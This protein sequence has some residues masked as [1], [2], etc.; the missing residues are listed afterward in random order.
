MKKEKV[1]H[2]NGVDTTSKLI[3]FTI[4]DAIVNPEYNLQSILGKIV[5]N[6]KYTPAKGDKIWIFPHSNIPRFKLKE[7]CK[8]YGTSIVK[9]ESKATAKFVGTDYLFKI[10]DV[11]SNFYKF[12]MTQVLEWLQRS[13]DKSKVYFEY[14]QKEDRLTIKEFINLL[15]E[16]GINE[17]Y[18][19]K[20]DTLQFTGSEHEKDHLFKSNILLSEEEEE[21]LDEEGNLYSIVTPIIG[22]EAEF[23]QILTDPLIYHQDELLAKISGAVMTE[24]MYNRV[25]E[26][27]ESEDVENKKLAIEAMGSCD[28]QKSAVYLLLLLYTNSDEIQYVSSKNHV[29]FKSLLRFFNLRNEKNVRS[30]DDII[31]CLKYQKLFNLTNLNILMP[32]AMEHIRENGEMQNIKIKDVE[33]SPEAESALAENILDSRVEIV[34]DP[35]ESVLGDL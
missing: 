30:I 24:D 10:M 8:N 26:M 1:I 33:L 6:R 20:H 16:S 29:N 21:K 34:E 13:E 27:L 17:V 31:E 5:E 9:E 3:H 19:D 35:K 4:Q 12:E 18:I 7:M 32:L 28:F 15:K 11:T 25:K 14:H 23:D 22:C 2:I